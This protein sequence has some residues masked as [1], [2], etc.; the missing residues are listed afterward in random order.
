MTKFAVV[1]LVG[2]SVFLRVRHAS[3]PNWRGP[4][5]SKIFGTPP[6]DT[7]AVWPRATK[8]CMLTRGQPCPVY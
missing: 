5:V 2:K 4:R 8:F 1:T 6:T 7:H 3:Y